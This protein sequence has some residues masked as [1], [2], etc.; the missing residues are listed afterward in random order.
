MAES[1]SQSPEAP[2]GTVEAVSSSATHGPVKD[3]R[4]SILLVEGVGVE[5][6]VHSGATIQ[7][8][9]RVGESGGEPNLR[10]VHLIGTELLD[11]LNEAGFGVS[12]GLLGENVTTRGISLLELPTGTRVRL[13]E[14][15]VIELTGLRNP[16]SQLDGLRPGLMKATLDRDPDGNLIRRAGVMAVVRAGGEVRAGDRIEAELPAGPHR[17]LLPV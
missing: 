5:G 15:A 2:A 8:L 4:L 6:D 14:R 17:P 7:H 10:Q 11:E 3:N 1:Y 16:C 12:P 13:G 9:S